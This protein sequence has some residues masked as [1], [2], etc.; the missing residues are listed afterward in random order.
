[1][2]R[3]MAALHD[4][5]G[6]DSELAA[7]V[8]AEEHTGLRFT[9]HLADGE[10]TTVRAGRFAAPTLGFDVRGCLGFVM[11]DRVGDVDIHA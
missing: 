6:A 2:Q 10:R 5:A 4:G 8:I 7:A 11:E 3:N 9:A 1:M